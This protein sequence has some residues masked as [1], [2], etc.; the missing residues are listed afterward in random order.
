MVVLLMWQMLNSVYLYIIAI[1][2]IRKHDYQ[3][4][5]DLGHI[6]YVGYPLLGQF[7]YRLLFTL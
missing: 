6:F 4:I 1:S 7:F 3:V 5:R 2:V